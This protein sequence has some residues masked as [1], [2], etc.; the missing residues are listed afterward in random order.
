MHPSDGYQLFTTDGTSAG[1]AMVKDIAGPAGKYGLPGS[2]PTDL[3]AAGGL[4][5]FSATDTSHGTQL[6]A[7]SGTAAGTALLTTG[8]ASAGGTVPQ[9][10]AADGGTLYFTGFDATNKFQLWESTGTAA[11]TQQLTSGGSPSMG[12]NPQDLTA[13]GSTIYFAAP[14]GSHGCNCGRSPGPRPARRR[15]SPASTWPGA[16]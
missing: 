12:L 4:L 15:C 16:A 14:D 6:W 8:N 7:T 1:T 5:Y 11:G 10:L 13:A 9:F 3:T 2:Y